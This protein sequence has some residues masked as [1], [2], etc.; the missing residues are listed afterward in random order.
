MLALLGA[1]AGGAAPSRPGALPLKDAFEGALCIAPCPLWSLRQEVRGR[2]FVRGGMMVAEAG[3]KIG[4]EVG[5]AA[6]IARTGPLPEG[7]R[8]RVAFDLL[9]PAGQPIDSLQLVD[10]ECATCGEAGNPGV[11]LYL[12]RGRLRIDR[13]KIGIEHAWA[14]DAAPRLEAG[15]RHRVELDLLLAS[16]ASGRARVR[17]DGAPVLEGRGAT[18]VSS[19]RSHADRVQIGITANSNRVEAM[20]WFDNVT[21]ETLG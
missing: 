11:R 12:R 17:L 18:L 4:N 6:L 2:V 19:R 5:K 8:L 13:S 20:A 3:P 14:N 10:I 15:R 21:I 1:C 9:I 7:T 16:G